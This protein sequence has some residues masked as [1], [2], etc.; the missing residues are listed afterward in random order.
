VVRKFPQ[1]A[2]INDGIAAV[3]TAI[4]YE[5]THEIMWSTGDRMRRV[6]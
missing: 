5:K 1:T 3:Q 6:A 4:E 2:S